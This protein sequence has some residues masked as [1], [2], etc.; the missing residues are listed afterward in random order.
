[1]DGDAAIQWRPKQRS[2]RDYTN[3]KEGELGTKINEDKMRIN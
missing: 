1:V 3:L 2:N